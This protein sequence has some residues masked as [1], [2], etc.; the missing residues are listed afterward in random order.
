MF[1]NS[2]DVTLIDIKHF[3][4]NRTPFANFQLGNFQLLDYYFYST[5]D[6]YY[7]GH[8]E[9]HFNGFIFNKLPL[10]R[11]LKFQT[12]G[13]LNFLFTDGT[14]TYFE[15]GAGIE[16]I[17]KIARIDFFT[18]FLDG[19]QKSTGIRIGIGF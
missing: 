3:N 11:K 2:D 12:V 4:G 14:Q 9:H 6:N 13:S 8:Y 18:S 7:T 17:L 19:S 5:T 15:V 16:H 1:T 10:L